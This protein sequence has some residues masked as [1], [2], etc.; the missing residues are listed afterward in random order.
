MIGD[1]Y[2]K[3]HCLYNAETELYDRSLT[4]MR[5]KYDSTSAYIGC[6][7]EVR[8]KSNSYAYNLYLWCRRE[9]EYKTGRPFNSEQW[10]ECISAYRG[11]SAQSWIDLYEYLRESIGGDEELNISKSITIHLTED[12]VKEIISEWIRSHEG[13]NVTSDDVILRVGTECRGYGMAEH[14]VTVFKG[15]DVEVKGKIKNE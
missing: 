7:E 10:R 12:D 14:D 1:I 15:C 9:I 3:M 2:F 4:N 6:S 5:D 8:H 11:L 13:L